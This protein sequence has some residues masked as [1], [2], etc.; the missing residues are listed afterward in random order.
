MILGEPSA[1][2]F[3]YLEGLYLSTSVYDGAP[4]AARVVCQYLGLRAPR[5]E[6]ETRIGFFGIDDF[7]KQFSNAGAIERVL[8]AEDSR[9]GKNS[10]HARTTG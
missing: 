10:H 3:T 2:K 8:G 9:I 5:A 4:F 6:W 1:R 7:R